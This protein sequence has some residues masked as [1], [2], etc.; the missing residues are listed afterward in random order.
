MDG[1][2]GEFAVDGMGL[3]ALQV[4]A[5]GGYGE[6]ITS[7]EATGPPAHSML[8]DVTSRPC[9]VDPSSAAAAEGGSLPRQASSSSRVELPA[10]RSGR[11][12]G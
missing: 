9:E 4:G 12:R 7:A 3:Q 6:E 8:D 11:M 5:V 1:S 10:R 2:S